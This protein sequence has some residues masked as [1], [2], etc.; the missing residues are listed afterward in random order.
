MR[1]YPEI[2]SAACWFKGV[3]KRLMATKGRLMMIWIL[4]LWASWA[5]DSPVPASVEGTVADA[6][7]GTPIQGA[8]V[9]ITPSGK[10]DCALGTARSNEEGK[11]AFPDLVPGYYRV[12]ADPPDGAKLMSPRF[13]RAHA[14]ELVDDVQLNISFTA[15]TFVVSV[16]D[17]EGKAIEEAKITRDTAPPADDWSGP[18]QESVLS[19]NNGRFEFRNAS[20]FGHVNVEAE[21]FAPMRAMAADTTEQLEF[22]MSRL[23][24]ISGRVTDKRNRPVSEKKIIFDD[25]SSKEKHG[26]EDNQPEPH[27]VRR[28]FYEAKTDSQGS[29]K[30]EGLPPGQFDVNLVLEERHIYESIYKLSKARCTPS[31]CEVKSGQDLTDLALTVTAEEDYGSLE[32][33]VV[34]ASTGC[35]VRDC[36]AN[37]PSE[38]REEGF[39][40]LSCLD[41]GPFECVVNAEGYLPEKVAVVVEPG[42]SKN[43]TVR[44]KRP[45][46]ILGKVTPGPTPRANYCEVLQFAPGEKEESAET[47]V[48]YDGSFV[49]YSA[50]AGKTLLVARRYNTEPGWER[51]QGKWLDTSGNGAEKMDFDLGGPVIIKG[52][53]TCPPGYTGELVIRAA[54]APDPVP[55]NDP[56]AFHE[57][58]IGRFP[59]YHSSISKED[60]VIPELPPGQYKITAGWRLENGQTGMQETHKIVTLKDG[61]ITTLDLSCAAPGEEEEILEPGS[62]QGTV[63]EGAVA[64]AANGKP[65]QNIFVLAKSMENPDYLRRVLTDQDGRFVYNDMPAGGYGISVTPPDGAAI[66]A[67]EHPYL[68][69]RIELGPSGGIKNIQFK[70]SF[71]CTTVSGRVYDEEGNPVAGAVIAASRS[72]ARSDSGPGDVNTVSDSEGRYCLRGL[73]MTKTPGMAATLV[74]LSGTDG[75]REHDLTYQFRVTA[76]GYAAAIIPESFANCPIGK[77]NFRLIKGAH[78]SGRILDGQGNPLANKCINLE[79]ERNHKAAQ[80]TSDLSYLEQIESSNEVEALEQYARGNLWHTD[81]AGRFAFDYLRPGAYTLT[82]AVDRAE[83]SRCSTSPIE[84]KAGATVEQNFVVGGTG[85]LSIFIHDNQYGLLPPDLLKRLE[86][87]QKNGNKIAISPEYGEDGAFLVKGLAPG[88]ILC[89]IEAAGC[90]PEKRAATITAANVTNIDFQV[91]GACAL[92]GRVVPFSGA[93]KCQVEPRLP[94]CWVTRRA[95]A[96]ANGDYHLDGLRAGRCL[97]SACQMNDARSS[98][99]MQSKWVTVEEGKEAL[100]DFDLS[101]AASISGAFTF[102][103]E[104]SGIVIIRP[105]DAPDSI[106]W[107]DNPGFNEYLLGRALCRPDENKFA[108]LQLPAGNYKVT[109]AWFKPDPVSK[110]EKLDVHEIT[111]AVSLADGQRLELNFEGK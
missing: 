95:E 63:V 90:R 46:V 12:I 71:L 39:L 33:K 101:G 74:N 26:F 87:T 89:E 93:S 82:I 17:E 69:R 62:I 15:K 56:V 9:R 72:F 52:H 70:I 41:P 8:A 37:T 96:E 77:M 57:Q 35:P 27:I 88:E 60:Y 102:P 65:L 18:Q 48:S 91:Q 31:R 14:G 68:Y 105:A 32:L 55:W 29:F 80:I 111:Q 98:I 5:A 1:E 108:L 24:S 22:R 3:K 50:R 109:A 44:L 7:H 81:V 107:N 67:P 11:F 61:E 36:R 2:R 43:E 21:G 47:S 6:A 84:L 83:S 97:F 76:P 40:Y 99:R 28:Q 45:L 30:A 54:D 64:D 20:Y 49:L 66:F 100:A 53:I 75:P 25:A 58:V 106:P 16:T 13:L 51:S 110:F 78:L 92:K 79:P 73:C 23:G 34:D 59:F 85:D 10:D 104:Y 42:E 19:D 38:E 86:I 94:K 103:A 4:F